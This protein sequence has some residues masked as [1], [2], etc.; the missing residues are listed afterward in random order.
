MNLESSLLALVVITL[1]TSK[2]CCWA[3]I[4]ILT[5]KLAFQPLKTELMNLP[6]SFPGNFCPLASTRGL[7]FTV[8]KCSLHQEEYVHSRIR[9]QCSRNSMVRYIGGFALFHLKTESFGGAVE[10]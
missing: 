2:M 9:K 5:V 4:C 10:A 1:G 8:M 7:V 6:L 3:F